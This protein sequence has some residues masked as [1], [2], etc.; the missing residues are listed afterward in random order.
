MCLHSAS[1][2]TSAHWKAHFICLPAICPD[3]YIRISG[4]PAEDIILLVGLPPRKYS[5]FLCPVKDDVELKTTCVCSILYD[6]SWVYI[7]Q[8]GIPSSQRWRSITGA[9]DLTTQQI[10]GGC[11][12]QPPHSF[13]GDQN[14][15]YQIWLFRLTP[16]GRQLS[17]SIIP[18]VW[19][20]RM[21][22][23]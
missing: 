20:G 18:T 19:T 5:S 9:S 2:D 17:W 22:W 15:L 23:I 6:C 4:M 12:P 8:T 14:L 7:G 16:S 11:Q 10:S 1:K 3:A 13:L 21:A